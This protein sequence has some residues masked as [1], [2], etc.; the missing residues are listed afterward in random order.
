MKK[1]GFG[2][3]R[4]PVKSDGDFQNI[5]MEQVCE[6]VDMYMKKGFNY[7][8]TAYPYHGEK[9]EE[10][11][12]EAVVK[13]YPRDKFLIADKMP[14][15]RVTGS[16]DYPLFFETQLK[17]CGVGYFDY[18]LLHNIWK[19]SFEETEKYGGFDFIAEKVNE[20]KIKHFG[21]S[22]HDEPELLEKVLSR[23]PEVEFV[24]L[25]INYFDWKSPSVRAE[26]CYNIARKYN[27]DIIIM[28]PN[29]GG[30]LV[31]LP[32][33][34]EK[35]FR[36]YAPNSSNASWAMR[37][38]GS[39]EGVKL[40]LSGMSNIEQVRDNIS[41]MDNF[42]PLNDTERKIIEQVRQIVEK[43]V[44]IDCTKC[45]YCTEDCPMGIPVPEF[46]SAFNTYKLTHNMGN[47]GMYYRRYANGRKLASE[48]IKCGRCEIHCPQHLEIRKLLDEVAETFEMK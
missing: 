39:L 5:D 35:L 48:C 37:Y 19:K 34:G 43:S 25:P 38:A 45:R 41:F 46:F 47:A 15:V 1:L 17:R 36:E 9:S 30:S 23:H 26:E 7:F 18:Y 10:A 32:I 20:G 2:F 8:D 13:R 3:M 12:R 11:L 29:K 22:F 21:F 16:K 42:V 4:L 27:K 14:T 31:N 6:M 40:V 28:E 24:Q 44:S 33:E